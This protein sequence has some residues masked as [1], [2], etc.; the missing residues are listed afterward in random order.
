MKWSQLRTVIWLRWRLMRNQFSRGG[1]INA[2]LAILGMI[3]AAVLI[4]ASGVGGLL[5]GAY[6]LAEQPPLVMLFA[7]DGIVGVF[8]FSWMIGVL[9]ELQ[10]S[11]AIDLARLLHLPVSP[12]GIFVMNYLA[13]H[14]TM[15]L[16][17]LLPSFVGLC[18]G[19]VW[20]R[21]LMM[22]WLFPLELSFIFMVTAWTYCL[23]G[24]LI[25][26]MV[27]PR[28][29]R[30]VL[31]GI[32]LAFVLA[33]QIPNLYFNVIVRNHQKSQAQLGAQLPRKIR[34]GTNRIEALPPKAPA[35]EPPKL[36]EKGWVPPGML[37]AHYYVPVLWLPKGAMALAEGNAWPAI[38]GVLGGF[39]I[40]A[41]GLARA[42]RS[43]I[44]F[45]LGQDNTGAVTRPAARGRVVARGT[46]LEKQVP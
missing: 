11:E 15:S 17:I 38:F 7:W 34:D 43:T 32:T 42:Y 39:L 24:W 35:Q 14:V 26:L 16:L 18:L 37:A 2:A 29:R 3:F 21:G 41:A 20:E 10:R 45:Y 1:A 5:G 13:S 30:N 46:F 31:V 6:V 12:R 4:V 44:R 27:N 28:R 22:I 9:V 8:L 25:A 33:G 36:G 40:G 23:R 19:L